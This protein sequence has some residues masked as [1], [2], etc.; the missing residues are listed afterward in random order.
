VASSAQPYYSTAPPPAD[1]PAQVQ[2][3]GNSTAPDELLWPK[4]PL[5]CA[6]LS[7]GL[8]VRLAMQLADVSSHRLGKLRRRSPRFKAFEADAIRAGDSLPIYER[9]RVILNF[10][11][12]HKAIEV[13]FGALVNLAGLTSREW[14]LYKNWAKPQP[15][16]AQQEETR[17]SGGVNITVSVG[18]DAVESVESRRAAAKQLLEQFNVNDK[19]INPDRQLLEGE[20]VNNS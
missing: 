20:V 14:E 19:Y 17:S 10:L 7:H 15:M 8:P 11:N 4:Y 5:Y 9:Q 16:V 2:V 6:A 1:E 3:V 12:Y 18:A 13:S